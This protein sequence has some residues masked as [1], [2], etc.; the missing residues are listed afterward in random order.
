M[1]RLSLPNIAFAGAFIVALGFLLLPTPEGLTPVMMRAAAVIVLGVGLWATGVVASYFGSLIFLFAAMALTVAPA[2]VVFSAFH[3]SAMWLV[4]G[5]LVIGLAVSRLGLDKRLVDALLSRISPSYLPVLYGVAVGSAAL[6]FLIPS[7]SGRVALLVPIMVA[8]S[9]RLGFGGSSRGRIGLVLCATMGTM[10]S[11]FGILPANVPNM[12]FYGAV[13]SIYGFQLAYWDYLLIAFPVLGIGAVIFYP[14]VI[15]ALFRETPKPVESAYEPQPWSAAEIRLGLILAAALALWFTDK[16]HGIAPAWVALGAAI[17]CML[18][19]VGMLSPKVMANDIN[20]SPL[21]FL[22]GVISLGAVA[23][24]SGL[25][26]E[27]AQWMLAVIPF[28]PDEHFRNFMSMWGMAQVVGLVTTMPAAPSIL[29]PMAQSIADVTGWPLTGVLMTQVST[30]TSFPFHYQ[31]PPLILAIALADLRFGPVIKMLLSY[32]ILSIV[33][34]LPLYYLWGRW[35][36]V[37]L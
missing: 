7:A 3:S 32:M 37:F 10:T 13:E 20:Y 14:L 35:L 4:F 9:D 18:P 11:S 25:G 24:N 26:A 5:G 23:T 12:V 28:S 29:T 27:V 22:A 31:A 34:L 21:I 2:D 16:L 33:V 17:L 36:G 1:P 6:G 30:W 8:L 15:F 19:R